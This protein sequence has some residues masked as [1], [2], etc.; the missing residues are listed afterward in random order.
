MSTF[1]A[2]DKS[3][4]RLLIIGGNGFVGSNILPRKHLRV[5][6]CFSQLRD[7]SCWPQHGF[8]HCPQWQ[9]VHWND[10]ADWHIRNVFDNNQLTELSRGSQEL[11]LSTVGAFGDK[12]FVKKMCC[13]DTIVAAAAAQ[14]AVV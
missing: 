4:H 6:M 8:A 13:D 1:K 3:K 2:Y 7:L 12:K 9:D 11:V 10:D 5:S 14:K